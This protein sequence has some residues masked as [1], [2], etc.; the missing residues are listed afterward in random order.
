MNFTDPCSD[1]ILPIVSRCD[2]GATRIGV[3]YNGGACDQSFTIQPFNQF[4]CTDFAGSPLSTTKPA[5]LHVTERNATSVVY[6]SG[7]VEAG[8][9]YNLTNEGDRLAANSN[10]QVFADEN[11]FLAGNSPIQIANFHTSCSQNLFLKDRFGSIQIVEF[12]NDEGVFSRF[13]PVTFAIDV[14]NVAA[15]GNPITVTEFTGYVASDSDTLGV[16][17]DLLLQL[18]DP[19]LQPGESKMVIM[20]SEVDMTVRQNYAAVVDVTAVTSGGTT[21]GATDS[22]VFEA[23]NFNRNVGPGPGTNAGIGSGL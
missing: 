14:G 17:S 23:G 20:E 12:E 19:T 10:H 13:L 3:K 9:S 21:C 8:S 16:T 15:G 1:R 22:D 2:V 18:A 5:Y 4:D 6:F 11:D 7:T